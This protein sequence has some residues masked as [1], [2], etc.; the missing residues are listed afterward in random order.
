M[1]S[2][3]PRAMLI[4]GAL[5]A[6]G[7]GPASAQPAEIIPLDSYANNIRAPIDASGGPWGMWWGILENEAAILDLRPGR[8]VVHRTEASVLEPGEAWFY[9]ELTRRED[10]WR[11][12]PARA[13][14]DSVLPALRVAEHSETDLILLADNGDSL[15]FNRRGEST[16]FEPRLHQFTGA[17]R[18]QGERRERL[19][20][21]PGRFE[22]KVREG[23]RWAVKSFGTWNVRD[24]Q[25]KMRFVADLQTRA[26]QLTGYSQDWELMSLTDTRFVLQD[27][28]GEN[29]VYLR[30]SDPG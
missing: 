14:D 4:A 24:G 16:S 29:R 15:T 17:W 10:Q 25:L 22:L 26:F 30:S 1:Y 8:Y 18:Q 2:V 13:V 9:G 12:A 28:G 6:F 3:V 19:I 5:M 11:L 7:P 21:T 23:F 27:A 20:M